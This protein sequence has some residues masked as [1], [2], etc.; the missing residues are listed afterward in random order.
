MD[1]VIISDTVALIG[2]AY[3]YRE[4]GFLPKGTIVRSIEKRDGWLRLESG[5]GNEQCWIEEAL[6]RPVSNGISITNK[7]QQSSSRPQNYPPPRPTR[8]KVTWS[9]APRATGIFQ[10]V[11][12]VLEVTLGIGGVAVPEP[13]TTVGGV[14]LIA[15][16][17]DT[18]IA[19]FRTLWSGQV[20]HSLTQTGATVAAEGFGASPETARRIGIGADFVAGVGPSVAFS[21]TR[22]LAIA[23]AEQ[24]SHKVAVAY[25][26]RSALQ[27]G[28]NAIGV[29]T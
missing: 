28:H 8:G 15:H 29:K 26:R 14:I 13:T 17:A 3:A 2:P 11:G 18:I 7:L 20:T 5:I 24:A 27:M 1:S 6:T 23:G 12:G 25:L 16:G 22:R 19:G 10:V 21:V 9:W 4:L